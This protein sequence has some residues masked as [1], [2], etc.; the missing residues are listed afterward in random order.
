MGP[1]KL[2]N[3]RG[4][5]KRFGNYQT[6]GMWGGGENKGNLFQS[7][8]DYRLRASN[9]PGYNNWGAGRTTWGMLKPLPFIKESKRPWDIDPVTGLPGGKW[10]KRNAVNGKVPGF[11]AGKMPTKQGNPFGK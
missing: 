4:G 10:D 3:P 6:Y 7:D 8:I 9:Q 2:Y 5:D 1:K 11:E